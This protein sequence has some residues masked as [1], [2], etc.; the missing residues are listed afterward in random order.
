[1]LSTDSGLIASDYSEMGLT[2]ATGARVGMYSPLRAA[3]QLWLVNYAILFKFFF[4]CH[5]QFAWRENE[6]TFHL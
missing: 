5:V 6:T 4:I 1:M 2:I 3:R